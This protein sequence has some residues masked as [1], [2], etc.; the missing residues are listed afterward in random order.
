MAALPG[1][2]STFEYFP[3]QAATVQV[4]CQELECGTM[5][6]AASGLQLTY[7]TLKPKEATYVRTAGAG[8]A[9]RPPVTFAAAALSLAGLR[10][11]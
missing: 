11:V 8:S 3:P 1:I 9:A 5:S 2:L 6:S 4:K 7:Y 10:R